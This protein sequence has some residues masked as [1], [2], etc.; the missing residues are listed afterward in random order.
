MFSCRHRHPI[1]MNEG[2]LADERAARNCF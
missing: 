1:E 2:S